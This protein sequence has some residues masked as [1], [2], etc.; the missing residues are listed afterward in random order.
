MLILNIRSFHSH[1]FLQYCLD[2]IAINVAKQVRVGWNADIPVHPSY[3][4]HCQETLSVVFLDHVSLDIIPLHQVRLCIKKKSVWVP[5]STG[6]SCLKCHHFLV[7]WFI[8]SN[9]LKME[10]INMWFQN[11]FCVQVEAII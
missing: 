5:F 6:L 4:L 7:I 1:S 9:H 8:K 2:S 11:L 10:M 3:E